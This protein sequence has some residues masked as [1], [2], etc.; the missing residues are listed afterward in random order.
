[1]SCLSLSTA[2]D[3][4]GK[5]S[6]QRFGRCADCLKRMEDLLGGNRSSI[7][8]RFSVNAWSGRASHARRERAIHGSPALTSSTLAPMLRRL[9][10]AATGLRLGLGLSL[11]SGLLFGG[12]SIFFSLKE[13]PPKTC[14]RRLGSPPPPSFARNDPAL[15]LDHELG[16]DAVR[17][18]IPL[19][20]PI[21]AGYN[22]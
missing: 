1:M 14:S 22:P 15:Q 12:L 3:R 17:G 21:R 7:Q 10:V 2:N 6:W 4:A 11:V 5:R 9:W 20:P 19:G 16:W 18:F 8:N 13:G